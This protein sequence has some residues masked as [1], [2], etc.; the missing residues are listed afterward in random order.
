M[1]TTAKRPTSFDVLEFDPETNA[2]YPE[3]IL[4]SK[5]TVDTTGHLRLY[6]DTPDEEILIASYAPRA[7][8]NV[9]PVYDQDDDEPP[10]PVGDLTDLPIFPKWDNFFKAFGRQNNPSNKGENRHE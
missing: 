9:T 5:I 6:R 4:A 1:E 10:E 3:N 7:W 8:V 2:T